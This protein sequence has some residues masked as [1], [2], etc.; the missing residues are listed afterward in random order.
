MAGGLILKAEK[1]T[2]RRADVRDL[3][4]LIAV[5]SYPEVAQWWAKP[6]AGALER[7]LLGKTS[8]SSPSRAM[9]KSPV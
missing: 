7:D 4:A 9:A 2:L 1:L 3:P 6:D 8:L 5:L